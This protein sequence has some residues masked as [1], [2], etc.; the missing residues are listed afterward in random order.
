MAPVELCNTSKKSKAWCEHNT[1]QVKKRWSIILSLWFYSSSV[2]LYN[3]E[4]SY[5]LKVNKFGALTTSELVSRHT[6]RQAQQHVEWP[7]A[8]GN[9]WVHRPMTRG[10]CGL[11]ELVRFQCFFLVVSVV[12]V[13]CTVYTSLCLRSLRLI[14]PHWL[15]FESALIHVPSHLHGSCALCV[16]LIDLAYSIHFSF[17][18]SVS[19]ITCSSSC[20][21]TSSSRMWSLKSWCNSAEDLGT[22]AENEPPTGYEPK[23]Y[24]ITEAYV[25][26]SQ[27]SIGEHRS[28][29]DSDYDDVTI[30][31]MLSDACRRRADHSEE[32]LSSCLSSSVSH[33]RTGRP[34]V[35]SPFVSQT[36]KCRTLEICSRNSETKL[37]KRT[38]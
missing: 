20:L 3:K 8:C 37:W 32:G 25:D 17:L 6:E 23:E 34:V 30:G 15:K 5:R 33:D 24:H 4:F 19:L 9:S 38:D 11:A 28:A 29:N 27:E 26:Y 10:R 21:S 13:F 2:S 14:T 18:I 35:C 36:F 12:L 31:K 1:S 16:S 22:L 7:E